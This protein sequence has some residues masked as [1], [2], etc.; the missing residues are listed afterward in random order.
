TRKLREGGLLEKVGRGRYRCS[1]FGETGFIV[2]SLALKRL[3]DALEQFENFLKEQGIVQMIQTNLSSF[4]K[5]I[6]LLKK[7]G[8]TIKIEAEKK[9]LFE[10]IALLTIQK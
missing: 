3:I 7:R 5:T 9:F 4:E 6:D 2:M 1:E 10:K 8:F